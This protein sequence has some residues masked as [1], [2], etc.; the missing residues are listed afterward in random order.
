MIWSLPRG[1]PRDSLSL[2]PVSLATVDD[3][4]LLPLLL[5]LAGDSARAQTNTPAEIY[6]VIAALRS[7]FTN[8]FCAPGFYEF[9]V[10]V[11]IVTTLVLLFYLRPLFLPFLLRFGGNSGRRVIDVGVQPAD[12]RNFS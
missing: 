11:T 8:R 5:M 12:T 10:E 7:D 1:V 4:M 9:R 2:V 3:V 6:I